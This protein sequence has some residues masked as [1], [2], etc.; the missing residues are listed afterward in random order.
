M[1]TRTDAREVRVRSIRL[2]ADGTLAGCA[3]TGR[4]TVMTTP[5]PGSV[6]SS[7]VPP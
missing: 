5:A 6:S 2:M 4:V 1:S 3:A 7:I